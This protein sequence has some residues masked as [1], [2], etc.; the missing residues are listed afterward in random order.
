MRWRSELPR[1]LNALVTQGA[2]KVVGIDGNP[3][4]IEGCRAENCMEQSSVTATY[5]QGFLRLGRAEA[6]GQNVQEKV[7]L[8]EG[9]YYQMQSESV[10][11]C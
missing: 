2:V 8:E 3:A 11:C 1:R 6:L 9:T 10:D 7:E 4:G 5:M